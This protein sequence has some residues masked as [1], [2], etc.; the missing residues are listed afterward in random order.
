MYVVDQWNEKHFDGVSVSIFLPM[1]L[2]RD[3]RREKFDYPL[4]E[5]LQ[6]LNLGLV[7]FAGMIPGKNREKGKWTLEAIVSDFT[8]ALPTIQSTL[9]S[10][11]APRKTVIRTEGKKIILHP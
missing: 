3:A 10:C 11:N 7:Q 6:T 9:K 5:A 4:N 8:L 1:E 2:T